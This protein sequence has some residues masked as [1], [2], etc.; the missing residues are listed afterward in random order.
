MKQLTKKQKQQLID[1]LTFY[2]IMI[3]GFTLFMFILN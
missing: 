3:I 1:D 2:S